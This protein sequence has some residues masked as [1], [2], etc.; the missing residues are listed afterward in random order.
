MADWVAFTVLDRL[1]VARMSV[2]HEAILSRTHR[3]ITTGLRVD[4]AQMDGARGFLRYSENVGIAPVY[5]LAFV[6]AEHLIE[7]RGLGAVVAY[8]RKCTT[9][10]DRRTLFEQS[11]GQRLEEF[12]REMVE[13]L[14]P[15]AP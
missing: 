15:P 8:F 7:R 11:F 6:F 1:G 2:E 4:L 5:Q 3:N 10:S 9:D 12:E 14:R 13:A